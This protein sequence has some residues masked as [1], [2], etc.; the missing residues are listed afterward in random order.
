MRLNSSSLASISTIEEPSTIIA[1][2]KEQTTLRSFVATPLSSSS[3]ASKLRAKDV[4]FFDPKYPSKQGATFVAFVMNANKHVFY[5]DVYVFV[6][7]L[8][9]LVM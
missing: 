3:T 2:D 5:R 8:K 9:D 7:R 6:D 1:L 4:E